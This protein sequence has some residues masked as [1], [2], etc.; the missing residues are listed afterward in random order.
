[1]IT[2]NG[3]GAGRVAARAHM[4]AART[5][6]T[7]LCALAALRVA[8]CANWAYVSGSVKLTN[9]VK[10]SPSYWSPR[11]GHSAVMLDFAVSSDTGSA[12]E[13]RIYMMGGEV[14]SCAR[15][16]RAAGRPTDA[17]AGL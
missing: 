14:S 9:V 12:S 17:D 7:A 10:N 13:P 8:Q 16:W 1:M 2:F 5:V 15:G 3:T 11:R 4:R 6:A